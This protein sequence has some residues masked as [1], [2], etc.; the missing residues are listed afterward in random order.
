MVK[1]KKFGLIRLVYHFT[2]SL[3]I[4]TRRSPGASPQGWVPKPGRAPSGV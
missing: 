3:T 4:S 2:I 1:P